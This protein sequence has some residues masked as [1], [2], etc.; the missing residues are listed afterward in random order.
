MRRTFS[1]YCACVRA[2]K[3]RPHPPT[4]RKNFSLS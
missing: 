3:M 1:G 2:A 4:A